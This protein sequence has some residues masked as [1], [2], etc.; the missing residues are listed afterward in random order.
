MGKADAWA[1]YSA[2]PALGLVYIPVG[3]GLNDEYG[4]HRPGAN[5]FANSIVALDV[6]TGL[7]QMALPDG[8]PRR[9]G[10][11]LPDGAESPRRHRRRSP[12]KIIAATSKQG[13]VYV[14][15]RVTGQP[16][17]PIPETPVARSDVPGEESWP[18]QPI[19]SKPAP[20]AQQGLQESD[21]IDYTPAIRDSALKLAKRCRMGPYFLPAL[22]G[23]RIGARPLRAARGTH[24]A[25]PA[26]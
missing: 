16:I 25:R 22:S 11:R 2:D 9:V 21:L 10:L 20:Y 24:R 7:A 6:K 1:T 4:G 26:G 8:A 12:R 14:L 5:L 18:T 3:E 23:R 19:P 15:D 13:W 17:W